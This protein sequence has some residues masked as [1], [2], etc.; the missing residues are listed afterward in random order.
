VVWAET[1]T[2]IGAKRQ[3]PFSAKSKMIADFCERR[4]SGPQEMTQSSASSA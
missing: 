2:G 1:E 4:Q 3:P